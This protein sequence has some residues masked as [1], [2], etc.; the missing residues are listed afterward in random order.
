MVHAGLMS[1][2]ALLVMA[3]QH[4]QPTEVSLGNHSSETLYALTSESGM[5]ATVEESGPLQFLQKRNQRR[6]GDTC[7]RE[8]ALAESVNCSG[9]SP[10][11][12]QRL[13]LRAAELAFSSH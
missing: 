13:S 11:T 2:R 4:Q 5:T 9:C 10:N 6:T 12:V 8:V 7:I 1:E 3:S